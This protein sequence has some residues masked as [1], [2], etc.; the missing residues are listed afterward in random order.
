LAIPDLR[1]VAYVSAINTVAIAYQDL[2]IFPY[3]KTRNPPGTSLAVPRSA[4][5]ISLGYEQDAYVN[6][7][8]RLLRLARARALDHN[9]PVTSV[10]Q[11]GHGVARAILESA[12]TRDSDVRTR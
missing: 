2:G 8:E 1:T 4:F 5:P 12:R 10:V 9:V 3:G 7:E 6:W 11:I